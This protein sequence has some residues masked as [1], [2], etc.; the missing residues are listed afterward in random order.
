MRDDQGY[1]T[2]LLEPVITDSGRPK[3]IG[4]AEPD[5]RKL[6]DEA[7]DHIVATVDT[8]YDVHLAGPA[9]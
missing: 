7:L 9:N 4:R 3:L 5:C 6:D 8:W 1:Y 2:W